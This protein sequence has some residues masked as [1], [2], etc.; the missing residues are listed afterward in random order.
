MRLNAALD[1]DS[2]KI[3]GDNFLRA[4]GEIDFSRWRVKSP[5]T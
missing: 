1:R 3:C 4:G 5:P 2:S